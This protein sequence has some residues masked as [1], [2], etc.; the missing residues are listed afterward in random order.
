MLSFPTVVTSVINIIFFKLYTSFLS[1]T[2]LILIK[3]VKH[4]NIKIHFLHSFLLLADLLVKHQV[5][6]LV[7]P[8]FRKCVVPSSSVAK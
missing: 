4:S 1:T 6:T 5:L 7:I 8:T 3:R 2:K